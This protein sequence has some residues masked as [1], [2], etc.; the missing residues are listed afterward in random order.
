MGFKA[1]PSHVIILD[2]LLLVGIIDNFGKEKKHIT[3]YKCYYLCI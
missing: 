2:G 3:D 1:I